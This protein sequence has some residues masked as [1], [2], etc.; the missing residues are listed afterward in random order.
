MATS[1]NASGEAGGFAETIDYCWLKG[2]GIQACQRLCLP[3]KEHLRTLLGGKPH[4]APIPTLGADG[5]WP[6]DHLPIVVDFEFTDGCVP[7]QAADYQ[8]GYSATL[9]EDIFVQ[10]SKK[11]SWILRHGARQAGVWMD[12][13]GWVKVKDLLVCI[14]LKDLVHGEAELLKVIRQSNQEK[15]RY[16]LRES[17]GIWQVKATGGITMARVKNKAANRSKAAGSVGDVETPGKDSNGALDT[18]SKDTKLM[19]ETPG[20]ADAVPHSSTQGNS[21]GSPACSSLAASS[22]FNFQ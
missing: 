9:D 11:L 13:K 12:N 7:V 18:P 8:D 22:S 19:P 15:Q 17:K 6:S 5:S 10:V 4:P 3:N 20:D 21:G 2:V 14:F 1:S 16:E